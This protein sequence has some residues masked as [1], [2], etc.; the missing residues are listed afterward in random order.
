MQHDRQVANDTHMSKTQTHPYTHWHT[1]ITSSVVGV[2]TS[3]AD[4]ALY[5]AAA[6][7]LL[8]ASMLDT[9]LVN[10]EISHENADWQ[11]ASHHNNCIQ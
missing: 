7:K 5:A 6:Y 11:F 3:C 2:T 4:A 8:D 10:T 1:V 9:V